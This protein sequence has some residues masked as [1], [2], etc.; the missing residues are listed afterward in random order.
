M[1]PAHPMAAHPDQVFVDGH[2][3]RQVRSQARVRHGR[4]YVDYAAK[5]LYVGT[6]PTGRDVRASTLTKAMSIQSAGVTVDGINVR[7]FAPSV[8]NMGAITVERPHVL[9]SHMLVR[10]M[11]TTGAFVMSTDDRL[12]HVAFRHNGLMGFMAT[13]ATGLPG[14]AT[15][16][17]STTTPSSST[18]PRPP[19]A[20]RSVAPPTSG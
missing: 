18:S 14:R 7:G 13:H 1:N 8:P 17:R 16:R 3:L 4:F 6:R 2:S 11:S 9:L 20:P 5:K 10:D 19:V 15:C 12:R